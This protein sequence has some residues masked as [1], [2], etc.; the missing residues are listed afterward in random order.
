MLQ[1]ESWE[2]FLHMG[3][4]GGYVWSAYLLSVLVV[5]LVLGLPWLRG[6][7]LL[8]QLRRATPAASSRPDAV[9]AQLPDSRTA[10]P[11][12]QQSGAS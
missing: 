9:I 7:L 8:K 4:H 12:T 11:S 3:G 2:A 6:R 1:F 10:A 5:G